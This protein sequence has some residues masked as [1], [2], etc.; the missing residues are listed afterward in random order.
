MSTVLAAAVRVMD[1]TGHRALR[2]NRAE[3]RLHHKMLRHALAH[4]VADQLAAEQIFQAGEVQL[5][6]ALPSQIAGIRISAGF[7]LF[8]GAIM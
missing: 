1:Q 2:C 8:S 7:R 3:Q 4:R 5:A 6:P